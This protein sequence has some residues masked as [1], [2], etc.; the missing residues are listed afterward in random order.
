MTRPLSA[1]RTLNSDAP[2]TRVRV[3]FLWRPVTD[4]RGRRHWLRRRRVSEEAVVV[5]SYAPEIAPV[6]VA[7]WRITDV[8]V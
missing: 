3:R 5:M 8:L 1:Y 6:P 4:Q 7:R 2:R